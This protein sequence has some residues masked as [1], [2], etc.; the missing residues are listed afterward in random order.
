M[1]HRS[2]IFQ[3]YGPRSSRKDQGLSYLLSRVG[4]WSRFRRQS[5]VSFIVVRVHCAHPGC[6]RGDTNDDDIF[7]SGLPDPR[8]I[9][10]CDRRRIRRVSL[11]GKGEV[12][13]IPG[14]PRE[15]KSGGGITFLLGQFTVTHKWSLQQV[16]PLR[17]RLLPRTSC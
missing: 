4:L 16:G 17:S 7:G 13:A 11:F 5:A 14:L 15:K 12:P 6:T 3:R 1:L 8:F 2:R 10:K 9:Y